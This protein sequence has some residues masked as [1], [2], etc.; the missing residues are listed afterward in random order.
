M[1]TL[2]NENCIDVFNKLDSNSINL[3]VTSPPYF[4]KKIYEINWTWEYFDELMK[5][6]MEESFRVLIPG[7]Y[8]AI[9]FGDNGFGKDNLNTECFST[10]PMS[11]YYWNIKG[12]F[13]LQSTRI[14]RKK[15]AKVPFNGQAR[16]YP[17]NLFDY[18]H[19]WVF[20]KPDGIGK[21]K[22]RDIKKS[23]R[24]VWG[25]EWNTSANLKSHPASFP[26]EL[27]TWLI[28]VYSDEGDIV[29]D[30]FMGAG[31]TGVA[32]KNLNR[33]FIGSEIDREF[34][35]LSEENINGNS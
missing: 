35:T 30:P 23:C 19:I 15:F 25:D 14:W 22:V 26:I 17:R 31:T 28:E 7:G 11:H 29:F 1:I 18:E 10:Y 5:K 2:Y 3:V 9:N 16:F 27:P 21:E 24:G 33:G 13:E 34:F 32:C 12:D 20:R 8:F 4:L 6:V